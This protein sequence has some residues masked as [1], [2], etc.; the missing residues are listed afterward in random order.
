MPE[1]TALYLPHT[2]VGVL[3][4]TVCC[5]DDTLGIQKEDGKKRL[6]DG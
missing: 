3:F 2:A 5:H 1:L 4:V 6:I